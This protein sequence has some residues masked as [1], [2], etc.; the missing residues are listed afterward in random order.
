MRAGTLIVR[1]WQPSQR[2]KAFGYRRR[3][4]AKP[5]RPTIAAITPST[6]I[7]VEPGRPLTVWLESPV[8]GGSGVED[9]GTCAWGVLFG[10]SGV[11]GGVSGGVVGGITG[12]VV[13]GMIGGVAG[14]VT[15]GGMAVVGVAGGT[16]A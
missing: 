4:I 15:P 9:G 10:A 7:V 16:C 6:E 8:A 11:A 1:G 2:A 5:A 3:A 14:G 12:G 13:G